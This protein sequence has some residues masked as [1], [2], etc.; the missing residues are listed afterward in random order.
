MLSDNLIRSSHGTHWPRQ[1][2]TPTHCRTRIPAAP[3]AAFYQPALL[4]LTKEGCEVEARALHVPFGIS[5][6]QNRK[7]E[8]GLTRCKQTTATCSNSQNRR[9]A[10]SALRTPERSD[11]G[12]RPACPERSRGKHADGAEWLAMSNHN[13]L[14]R[15]T[16][17]PAL[18]AARFS[19][20]DFRGSATP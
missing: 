11:K 7:L 13:S 3:L 5:N 19:S 12:R 2:I 14:S 8:S 20:F 18:F 4:A 16:R 15:Y 9:S 6:R 17:R 1:G 10:P